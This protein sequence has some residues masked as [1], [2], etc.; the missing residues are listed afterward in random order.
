M[1]RPLRFRYSP[2]S[3]DLDRVTSAI[4]R[5]LDANLGASM[6]SPWY[7]LDPHYTARRFDMDNGDTALFAWSS[8]EGY[9]IGNTETPRSLWDTEKFAFAE[10]PLP[11]ATWAEQELLAEL[12]EEEPWLSPYKNL[13]RFFLPVLCSKDGRDS[14]RAFFREH[15]AGFPDSTRSAA[16]RFYDDF[17]GSSALDAYRHTMAGKL[18]TS[19][20]VDTIRM[21]ASMSEFTVAKLLSDA[22]Y[23]VTPE[24]E[25]STGH[26]IDFRAENNGTAT[27]VEVTRPTPPSQRSAP[28]PCSAIT[29]TVATKTAGQLDAHGGGITLFVDCSSFSRD[30]WDEVIQ[31]QP[32]VGHRPAVIFRARP[33]T[34]PTAY[35]S[36]SIPLDL[37]AVIDWQ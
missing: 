31:I 35:R 22:G 17:I 6:S 13:A 29:E 18:G 28:N 21:A 19:E 34:R 15:A 24:I 23:T 33:S 30:Q 8:T 32:P 1:A 12:L 26:A 36:G 2:Q 27:L 16:L 5:P 20:R 7:K 14:T 9:W 11:L 10:V 37:D 25:V 3:W 4:Y